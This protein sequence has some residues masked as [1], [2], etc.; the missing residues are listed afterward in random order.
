MNKVKIT[1]MRKASYPDLIEKYE[2]PI[3]NPCDIV[4][5]SVYIANGWQ[6]PEGFCDSA[7]ESLSP[8]V[9]M[10]ANGR[11]DFYEGWMKDPMSAMISCNDGFRPVSFLVEAMD[12]VAD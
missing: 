6:K 11:G 2:N 5:G 4:E 12:E 3:E 8:F 9:M 7:W 1:V 10:L